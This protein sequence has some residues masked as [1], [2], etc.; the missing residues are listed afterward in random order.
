M[1]SNPEHHIPLAATVAL[2]EDSASESGCDTF[3]L[4][5]AELRKLTDFGAISLLLTHQPT[6][7]DAV[8]TIT[9]Y[10][11]LLNE[12]LAI[13]IEDAG[14]TVVLRVEIIAEIQTLA[15]QA[16]DLAVGV[17]F[18]MCW[19][20][21]G[22]QWHPLSVNF[23]HSAPAQTSVH[24]RIFR[25]PLAF[26]AEF[27]GIVCPS[28]DLDVL[29]PG[30]DPIMARHAARLVDLLPDGALS[31]A[32]S[33][34]R[35]VRK[36]IYVGL[37]MGRATIEQVAQAL[38]VNVRTLQR[39]LEEG[40]RKFTEM[41]DEVRRDLV[42]RYMENSN[43]SITRVAELLGYGALSSFTRW[44]TAQYGMAP[45]AWRVRHGLRA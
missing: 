36:A 26:N 44:F 21:L 35:D 34:E 10:Q 8:K 41:V 6:L 28:A 4:Q 17:L 16:T 43:Y 23:T 39:R 25:C 19:A 15:H 20:L 31:F 24:Q 3:G 38:G 13:H 9:Q 30:A 27:I 37:P 5:M 29:N 2:L 14:S 22:A 40:G 33:I 32:P 1:L 45:N 18:R 7:R 12:S 11:H 42:F